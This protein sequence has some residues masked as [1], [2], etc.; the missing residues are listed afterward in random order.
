VQHLF[1]LYLQRSP[2]FFFYNYDWLAKPSIAIKKK[3]ILPPFVK[4]KAL[5]F[6][7]QYR[8]ANLHAC[9]SQKPSHTPENHW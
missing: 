4:V 8:H 1:Q 5:L 9:S 2:L 3:D 7:I 6:S